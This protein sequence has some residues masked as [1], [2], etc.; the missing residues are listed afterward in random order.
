MTK[1]MIL[2]IAMV[3]TLYAFPS[4]IVFSDGLAVLV[5]ILYDNFCVIATPFVLLF[6]RIFRIQFFRDH[7]YN[8]LYNDAIQCL[9]T[10]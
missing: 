2:K 7:G 10:Y 5:I 9:A 1:F 4:Q 6:G 3:Y 8:T